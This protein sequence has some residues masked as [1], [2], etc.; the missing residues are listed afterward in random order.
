MAYR[1]LLLGAAVLL[2]SNVPGSAQDL[3]SSPHPRDCHG[4]SH[5]LRWP[6]LTEVVDSTLAADLFREQ[7]DSTQ[8]L[9]AV[10]VRYGNDGRVSHEHVTGAR[11]RA[12]RR[13]MTD[14]LPH[15]LHPRPEG[16]PTEITLGRLN[17]TDR[18]LLLAGSLA[19]LT[20]RPSA[21]ITPEAEALLRHAR[22][23]QS[24][25]Y[26]VWVDLVLASDA[27][28]ITRWLERSS[29]VPSLDTIALEAAAHLRYDAAIVGSQP[30][31]SWMRL[32]VSFDAAGPVLWPDIPH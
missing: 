5:N 30:V 20:C 24:K 23:P 19:S 11:D 1:Y 27:T 25:H 10:T 13:T 22:L 3:E 4:G 14:S 15:A 21:H 6:L 29:G 9:T 32:P 28:V 2:L 17:A 8:P 31:L 12:A 7:A 16:S 26:R 18:L